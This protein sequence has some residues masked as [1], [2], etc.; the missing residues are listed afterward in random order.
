MITR[1]LETRE[2]TPGSSRARNASSTT[3]ILRD[4]E[5]ID[6]SAQSQS[7][8]QLAG[9]YKFD[10]FIEHTAKEKASSL[11]F[12]KDGLRKFYD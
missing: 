7:D 3:E 6:N 1:K 4:R 9:I 10:S 12:L 2:L 11:I 5:A 8:R